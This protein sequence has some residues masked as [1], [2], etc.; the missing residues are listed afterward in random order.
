MRHVYIATAIFLK[1][2]YKDATRRF[3]NTDDV[4]FCNYGNQ[5]SEKLICRQNQKSSVLSCNGTV[6]ILYH[7]LSPPSLNY[8][9]NEHLLFWSEGNHPTDFNYTTRLGVNDPFEYQKKFHDSKQNYICPELLAKDTACSLFWISTHARH[10]MQFKDEVDGKVQA[11]NEHMRMFFEEGK[12]GDVGYIDVFNMTSNLIRQHQSEADFMTFDA[13]HWGM[14][15]NL[16]KV[17]IIMT[18][19]KSFNIR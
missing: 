18:A 2:N 10:H 15:V 8:C 3:N 1:N 7:G 4:N 17:Q 13:A 6:E 19:L 16:V 12:C 11:F 5:F 14:E 9:S